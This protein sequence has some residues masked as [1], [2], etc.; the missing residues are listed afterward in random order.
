MSKVNNG[1]YRGRGKFHILIENKKRQIQMLNL[2]LA[3]RSNR[4]RNKTE[5][6]Q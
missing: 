1:N 3:N 6:G 5:V 4:E 2:N